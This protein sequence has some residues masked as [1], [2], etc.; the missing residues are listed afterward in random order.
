LRKIPHPSPLSPACGGINSGGGKSNMRVLILLLLLSLS[1]P[2]FSQQDTTKQKPRNHHISSTLGGIFLSA[3]TGISMPLGEFNNNSNVTFGV[4]G[5]IEYSTISI[6]PLVLGGEVTYFSYG[7]ADDFKTQ[8]L[9]TT[10]NTKI[11]SLGLTAE[12]ALSKYF[13]IV[14]TTPFITADVKYNMIKR[15]ISPAGTNLQNLP[16]KENK[17]SGA[18][19]AGFTLF[20]LDFSVKYIYMKD[21]SGIG[22]FAKVRFPLIRFK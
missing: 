21:A 17:V 14:Y 12:Y 3:G 6:F 5:R 13:R 1:H 15:E 8:N 19:G 2:I 11:L 22:I 9:L 16:E 10:F 7:G 4:L 20:V 18:I